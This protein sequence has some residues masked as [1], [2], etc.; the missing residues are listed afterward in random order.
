V[1]RPAALGSALFA[2]ACLGGATAADDGELLAM[3][4]IGELED[5]LVDGALRAQLEHT[6][7]PRLP[8]S[9]ASVHGLP[10][11]SWIEV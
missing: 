10:V 11:N 6:H 2:H 9:V 7:R 5:A 8:E 4:R 1:R 3:L